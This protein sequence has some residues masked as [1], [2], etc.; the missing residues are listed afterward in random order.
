V[1]A[2]SEFLHFAEEILERSEASEH[3]HPAAAVAA[4]DH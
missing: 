1:A 3:P 4:H 2:Y